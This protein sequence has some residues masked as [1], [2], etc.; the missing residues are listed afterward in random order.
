MRTWVIGLSHVSD[1]SGSKRDSIKL[2]SE[3]SRQKVPNRQ[4]FYREMVTLTPEI[5]NYTAGLVGLPNKNNLSRIYK[6]QLLHVNFLD[7]LKR[8][9]LSL[10]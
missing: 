5:V 4:P 10:I 7:F 1:G 8:F 2:R 6:D 9:F 3:R